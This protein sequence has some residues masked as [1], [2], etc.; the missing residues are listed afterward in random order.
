VSDPEHSGTDVGAGSR[1]QRRP[2]LLLAAT[3][4][5]NAMVL[6]DQTAVPLALPAIMRHYGVGSQ[7][8]QWVL[9]GSLVTLATLLVLGGQLGDLLG[10]RRIFTIGTL[11]FAAA[12]ACAGTRPPM[13][14]GYLCL[15]ASG[16]LLAFGGFTF[17]YWLVLPGLVLYGGGL[18]VVLTVNDPVSVSDV[19]PAAQGSSRW[20]LGHRRTVRRCPRHGCS[21]L[22]FH[23]TY[24]A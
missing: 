2:G 23:T 14:T 18:A 16:L 20:R 3:T 24:I 19:P 17:N 9:N 11:V 15:A 22:I 13:L 7:M 4:L 21:Y 5:A 12:S 10:R 8:V 6:V 1:S